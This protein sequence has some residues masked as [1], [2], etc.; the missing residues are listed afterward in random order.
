MMHMATLLQDFRHGL[1]LLR[2]APGFSMSAILLLALGIGAN[3][4]V[5]STVDALVLQPRPGR[6]DTLVGV[7][8]R[9]RDTPDAYRDFAYAEY[10]ALRDRDDVFDSLMAHTFALVGIRDGETTK[11]HFV[12]VV[13][14]NYFTTLGVSLAA[15]RPFTAAEERPGADVPVAIAS[16]ST[17]RRR[18]LDPA[19]LGSTVSVNGMPFTVV[20]ITPKGFAGTLTIVSPEWW[21]PLGAY[22]MLVNDMFRQGPGGLAGRRNYALNL[23]GALKPGLSTGG[24]ARALASYAQELEAELPGP[25]GT[26]TLVLAGVPRLAVAS[27]PLTERWTT[28]SSALLLVMAGLVLVVACLNLANLLLARGASRR[29]EMAIR[30]A[31]GS[32]RRRIVQQVL[33]ESLA[34]SIAGAAVGLVLARWATFGLTSWL[35]TVLPLGIALVVEPSSRSILA[36]G[37]FAILSTLVF[38]LGPAWALSRPA[39]L[40]GASSAAGR[41][42]HG[43]GTGRALVI[44]QLAVSLTLVAVG[45]LF[46]RAAIEAAAADPGFPLAHQLVVDLDPSLVGY[47]DTDSRAALHEALARVRSLPGVEAASMAS[48]VPFGDLTEDGSVTLPGREQPVNASYTIVGSGYFDTLRLPILRGHEFQPEDDAPGDGPLQ[49]VIDTALAR[50]LFGDQD[51]VG[52]SIQIRIRQGLDPETLLIV[53]VAAAV[54]NDL[55]EVSPAPHVYVSYGAHVRAAM[56]LHLRTA[57]TVAEGAMLATVERALGE[58]EPRLP[59]LSARTLAMHRDASISEWAVRAAATSFGTFG[60][61]ALFLAALGVYGLKAYDVSRRTRE[62]GIRMALGATAGDVERLVV[63]EGVRTAALG[64]AIGTLLALGAGQLVAGLLYRVSPLDPIALVAALGALLFATLL[65]TYL[66]ARRA[67]RVAPLEALRSE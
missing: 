34:L 43:R 56:T 8:N 63:G 54:R 62:L 14:S 42:T 37:G 13:S 46:T 47:D 39:N 7:F 16:Y 19:F 5:F 15:G 17:W 61:L 9:D 20:G 23:A 60:G 4:A 2:R 6:I 25:E 64:L 67:A 33:A 59:V 57:P 31:L 65:A 48:A 50:R 32:G 40:N 24:A 51:A 27:R 18:G 44:G 36:A 10:V 11:R 3:T 38:A 52:R 66:P 35:A 12:T 29:H 26:R 55:F 49:A 45:A 21:F 58:I 28:T 30:Q 1:R 53:G 41:I 22:D